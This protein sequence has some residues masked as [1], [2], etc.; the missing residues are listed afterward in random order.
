MNLLYV[1]IE[2]DQFNKL[3]VEMRRNDDELVGLNDIDIKH[4]LSN[5]GYDVNGMTATRDVTKSSDFTSITINYQTIY[6]K[7]GDILQITLPENQN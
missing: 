1:P 3:R 5:D 4:I 2:S 6:G 7:T